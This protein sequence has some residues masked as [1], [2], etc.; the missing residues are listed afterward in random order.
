VLNTGAATTCCNNRASSSLA[1]LQFTCCFFRLRSPLPRAQLHAAVCRF[2]SF[3]AAR[4][5]N[6][7]RLPWQRQQQQQQQRWR[8]DGEEGRRLVQSLQWLQ[9]M[10]A[11]CTGNHGVPLAVPAVL[12]N[13]RHA[14]PWR[15]INGLFRAMQL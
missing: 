14:T 11:P 15:F 6:Y 12:K 1:R 13:T 3:L 9:Q 2:T 5:Y 4:G 10:V 7:E 8:E